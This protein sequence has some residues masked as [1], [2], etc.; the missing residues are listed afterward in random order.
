MNF[1]IDRNTQIV[2]CRCGLAHG[3]GGSLARTGTLSQASILDVIVVAMGSGRRHITKPICEIT[4]AIRKN[5]INTSVL[6]LYAGTGYPG[7]GLMG[8]FGIDKKEIMQINK[9]KLAI[10]HF[11]NVKNHFIRKAA[12]IFKDVNIPSVIICQALVDYEDFASVG[13]NTKYVRPIKDDSIG[14]GSIIEIIT[15]VTRG[16]SCTQYKLNEVVTK[17]KKILNQQIK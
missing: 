13:I 10:F 15:G 17:I 11:G 4:Y 5:N 6:V 2:D 14:N 8:S 9:H 12:E 1:N 16:E 7:S 3:K